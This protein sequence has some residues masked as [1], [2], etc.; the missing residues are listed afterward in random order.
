[1]RDYARELDRL[2]QALARQVQAHPEVLNASPRSLA[3]KLDPYYYVALAPQF[4]ARWAL[5]ASMR[6]GDAAE[7]LLRTGTLVSRRL[8][9]G[10]KTTITVSLLWSG[11]TAL[12]QGE[13]AEV[14]F[15][16]ASDI[17]QALKLHGVPPLD[18]SHMRLA[19][20]DRPVVQA[21]LQQKTPLTGVG[22]AASD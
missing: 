14:H 21:L 1:M 7:C 22:Y 16:Q 3:W 9:S 17:D 2:Y 13:P 12:A 10:R 5:W 20:S 6:P 19:A 4:M 18:V 8:P 11:G 15:F